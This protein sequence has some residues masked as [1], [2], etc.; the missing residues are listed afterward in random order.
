MSQ[1]RRRFAS[2][3]HLAALNSRGAELLRGELGDLFRISRAIR[4]ALDDLA[5]NH[6]ADGVVAAISQVQQ[7]EP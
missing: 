2:A 1:R 4:I 3:T 6:L 7:R 5:S